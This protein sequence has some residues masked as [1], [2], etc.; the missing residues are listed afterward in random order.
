MYTRL[1][2]LFLLT[3]AI[4]ATACGNTASEAAPAE[5][6]TAEARPEAVSVNETETAMPKFIHT[7]FFWLKEDLTDEQ[8]AAFVRDVK[9]LEKVGT[10]KAF[11]LGQPA[12]TPRDVVDNSYDYALILH[13][14]DP[15]GQDAYQ[16]DPIHLAFVKAQENSWTRVQVYDTIVE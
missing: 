2:F 16:V 6:T 15:A 1:T 7:V 9:T 10:I 8:R 3:L 13:F 5:E 14:A 4:F 11:H 12:K